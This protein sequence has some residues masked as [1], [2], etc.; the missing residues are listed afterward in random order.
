M[1]NTSNN[2]E[3]NNEGTVSWSQVAPNTH[4]PNDSC[5]NCGYC[6]HCGRGG[7]PFS[8]SYPNFPFY[9]TYPPY[10]W[11]GPSYVTTGTTSEHRY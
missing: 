8:P 4:E 11:Y 1:D 10:P 6:K 5:P 3:V 7:L 9:P 2:A